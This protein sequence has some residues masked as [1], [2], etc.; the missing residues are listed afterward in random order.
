MNFDQTPLSYITV[1]NT[2]LEFEGAIWVPVREKG[3][4]K[5]ITGTFTISA[6]GKFLPMHLIDAGKTERS[7]PEG[8]KSPSEIDVTHSENHWSNEILA[9][10]HVTEVIIPYAKQQR[11]ELGLS[12]DHKCLPIFEVF[13]GQTT[14]AHLQF[15]DEKFAY[16]FVPPN[17]TNHCQPLDLNVNSHAKT[18][19]KEK[20]QQWCA[21]QV[22]KELDSGRIIYQVDI[23]TRLSIMKPTHARWIIRLYDK[24]RNS[25]EM[26]INAFQMAS[27]T[28]ALTNENMEEDDPLSHL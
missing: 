21:Q 13:K 2:T 10:Q 4:S 9:C 22:Q 14:D 8:I 11:K 7:H 24:F 17:L 12:V 26:V 27:I 1:G 16:V 28:E 25:D 20:F 23:E 6:S 15:L 18:F 5:Q 3:K 19:L